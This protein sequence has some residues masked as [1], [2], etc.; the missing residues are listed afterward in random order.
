MRD[1]RTLSLEDGHTLRLAGIIV[2][3]DARA[4]LRRLINGKKIRLGTLGPGRDRYGRLVALA[5]AGDS[6][7]SLQQ[8]LLAAGE[9]RVAPR[10]GDMACAR[11]LLAAEKAA[12]DARRGLWADPRFLP[13]NAGDIGRLRAEAG[14]FTLVEGKVL[15]VHPTG[16]TIYLNFGRRWTRDFSV[17][18]LRRRQRSFVATG[19]DPMQLR[20]RTLRV[21][22]VIEMRRG[23]VIEAEAPE[24]IE[25]ANGGLS[26]GTDK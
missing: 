4:T 24:Q 6:R 10:V 9:A 23:P 8:A 13:I 2:T 17:I 26:P 22:G 15:S 19:I 11:R 5:F 25:L 14:K 21:R 18:I 16:G 7:T 20:G 12:R 1:G 3:G